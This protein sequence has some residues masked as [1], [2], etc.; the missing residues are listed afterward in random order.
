MTTC[1]APWLDIVQDE[2][3]QMEPAVVY[4]CKNAQTTRP[5]PFVSL[6]K[7]LVYFPHWIKWVEMRLA[8][9]HPFRSIKYLLQLRSLLYAPVMATMLSAM[10]VWFRELYISEHLSQ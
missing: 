5:V 3:F 8:E 9:F 10:I 1:H 2:I 7:C 6:A 4:W